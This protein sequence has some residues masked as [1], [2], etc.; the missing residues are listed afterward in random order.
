[1]IYKKCFIL[2]LLFMVLIILNGCD[3]TDL[4][5]E[6]I[7]SDTNVKTGETISLKL[8]VPEKLSE[9]HMVMW[10]TEPEEKGEI[11]WGEQIVDNFTDEELNNYFGEK[12]GNLNI[13]RIA[14]FTAKEKGECT[15]FVAGFYKQ[16]NPQPITSIKLKIE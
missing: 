8:K 7:V 3:H 15:I 6:V 16:T 11:I 2:S 5:G 4:T 14:L 13:D 12:R 1:M 10:R 9:I